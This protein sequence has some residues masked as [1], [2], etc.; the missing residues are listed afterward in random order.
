MVVLKKDHS[1]THRRRN[2]GER[3]KVSFIFTGFAFK[4]LFFSFLSK[5]SLRHYKR[6]REVKMK[7]TY[8]LISEL[9]GEDCRKVKSLT[10]TNK[11][12]SGWSFSSLPPP[13]FPSLLPFFSS[14]LLPFFPSSLSS[15]SS[16]LASF[17]SSLPFFPSFVPCLKLPQMTSFP[18]CL[19]LF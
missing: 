16:S 10:L 17:S 1:D 15:F 18:P 13:S 12:F 9:S 3:E 2:E 8:A 5:F 19:L 7:L 11:G 4:I 6:R 14:S